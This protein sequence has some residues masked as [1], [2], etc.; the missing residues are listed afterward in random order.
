MIGITGTDGKTTTTLDGGGDARGGWPARGRGRQHRGAAGGRARRRRRRVRGRV[1]QLPAGVRAVVPHRGRDLVEPRTRPS[2]LAHVDGSLPGGQGASVAAAAPDR[3]RH[4]LGRRRDGDGRAGRRAPGRHVTFALD[5]ADYDVVRRRTVAARADGRLRLDR[6]RCADGSRTTCPTRSPRRRRASRAVWSHPTRSTPVWP[7]SSSRRTG[8]NR[9]GTVRGIQ[10]FN[11]SK[12]TSPH[13]A[14]TAIRSFDSIVL[15][16]GG[17]NKGLDLSSLADESD[18]IRSVVAIGESAGEIEAAFAGVRPV[19]RATSMD[20]AVAVADRLAQTGRRGAAVAG[21]CQLRLV[22]GGWIPGPRRRLP[23]TGRPAAERH[24]ARRS[25]DMS[26]TTSTDRRPP[27]TG[28]R[29]RRGAAAP[30]HG[31]HAGHSPTCRR[32]PRST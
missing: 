29:T 12:A 10:W 32:P 30:S 16:A 18:R 7:R 27:P 22:P 25:Q 9:S 8:S 21:V 15:I 4:R 31:A 19:E 14:L 26:T 24:I 3:R 2:E 13:A 6:R 11:D 17:R 28:C 5:D 1:Q 23:S 20:E